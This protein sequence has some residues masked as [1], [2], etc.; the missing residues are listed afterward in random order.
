M[1]STNTRS[2]RR[3]YTITNPKKSTLLTVLTGIFV[4]Y[5]LLPLA[6][7]LVNATKTQ[8]D[9]A[10][11]FGFAFGKEFA[12]W[13][14]I[15]GVFTYQDGIFGRWLL[16]TVFY[17]VVGAAVS[18][19]LATTGGYA[20]AKLDFTGKKA[21][22]L[23]VLG[24]ISVPGTALAIPQFLLFAHLGMTNTPWAVLIPSFIN[25]FGLYLMW[26]FSSD[27]VPT[28]LLEAAKIDGA[29]EFRAFMQIALP[30]LAPALVTVVLFSFVSIWNN[31]FLPLV[32]LKDPNWYPLTI[33][34]NQWNMLGSTAGN[35]A[36]LQN[37]IITGSLLTIIPLIVAFI[38]L[39][40][41]WQSGLA[42][43]A[44]KE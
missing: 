16:N 26:V 11:S 8:P 41:Y 1:P 29:G 7:L 15:V 33:G 12:L 21:F 20:L 14:N 28:G 39:Q 35:G 25:P 40:R 32:M 31:Y 19:A 17:V 36:L 37:L 38:L 5:C 9:F 22:L 2:P 27:A 18:T 30:L 44:V 42:L 34:L 4:L 6:W 23:V 43:G 3:L 24:S 10:S 13:S